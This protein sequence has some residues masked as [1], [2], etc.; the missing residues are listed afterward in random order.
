MD[1]LSV[2]Q[3]QSILFCL[4]RNL[5]LPSPRAFQRPTNGYELSTGREDLTLI[6][7]HFFIGL[8]AP[9]QVR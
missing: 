6:G 3:S 1:P 5:T 7:V 8:L 4:C 9:Q 2:Q